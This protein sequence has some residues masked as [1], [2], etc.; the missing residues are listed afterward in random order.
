MP[1]GCAVPE[2]GLPGGTPPEEAHRRLREQLL[3]LTPERLGL[4]PP[5]RGPRVIAGL[6]ELGSPDGTVTL[7]VVADG[8]TSLHFAS[9]GG[10]L[11]PGESAPLRAAGS[12]FLAQVDAGLD[13]LVPA[14]RA[15]LPLP[16]AGEVRFHALTS[17]GPRTAGA[18]LAD[19]ARADHPLRA[20]YLA[21]QR[22][23]G[24]LRD[25][26]EAQEPG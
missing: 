6:M 13:V 25:L 9:G 22:V 1:C 23:I 7:A 12:A 21:G 18:P 3:S 16:G 11:E 20:L 15:P 26:K 14:G 10:V 24:E 4:D 17:E 19:V 8:T 5:P 2:P